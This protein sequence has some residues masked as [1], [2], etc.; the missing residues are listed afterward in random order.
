LDSVSISTRL[1][2][3]IE[4]IDLDNAPEWI[5]LKAIEPRPVGGR[6]L[7]LEI[8]DEPFAFDYNG[9]Q[10]TIQ[11]RQDERPTLFVKRSFVADTF[12]KRLK[13][14][15]EPDFLQLKTRIRQGLRP[16]GNTAPDELI[17]ETVSFR[18]AAPPEVECQLLPVDI[19]SSTLST[20][21]IGILH[22]KWQ[23][24]V[25]Y[26]GS[27]VRLTV[28][29]EFNRPG[30]QL[31]AEIAT[32]IADGASIGIETMNIGSRTTVVADVHDLPAGV[33]PFELEI[34]LMAPIGNV[35]PLIEQF[36][37]S[38]QNQSELSLAC[39]VTATV[40]QGSDTKDAR[41]SRPRMTA[42]LRADMRHRFLL[43][44]DKFEA[45]LAA[46]QPPTDI[47][48][49]PVSVRRVHHQRAIFDHPV[50]EFAVTS[51]PK[52]QNARL[53]CSVR[54]YVKGPRSEILVVPNARL[55]EEALIEEVRV[56]RAR[57]RLPLAEYRELEQYLPTSETGRVTLRAELTFTLKERQASSTY[58]CNLNLLLTLRRAL[59]PICIDIGTSATAVWVADAPV[60]G[61]ATTYRPLPLGEW[62]EEIDEWH[63]E[64]SR[65]TGVDNS[66]LIP[67][68]VGLTWS[69]GLRTQHNPQ[70]LGDVLLALDENTPSR[71]EFLDRTY[72]I[73]LP[74]PSSIKLAS[75]GERV[76]KR[77]KA[78]LAEGTGEIRLGIAI[79]RRNRQTNKI[80]RTHKLDVAKLLEDYIDELVKLYVL[81]HVAANLDGDAAEIDDAMRV[82]QFVITHPCGVGNELRRA[83]QDAVAAIVRRFV[84]DAADFI[85]PLFFTES[86]AAGRFAL[87]HL[88]Q[89]RNRAV[90][91]A[92]DAIVAALDIGAGT[93]DI[94]IFQHNEPNRATPL[95]DFGLP[96]GGDHLDKALAERVSFI[97][98][99]VVANRQASHVLALNDRDRDAYD[100]AIDREIR[101]AKIDLSMKC[102]ERPNF[103]WPADSLYFRMKLMDSGHGGWQSFRLVTVSDPDAR[104]DQQVR[105]PIDGEDVILNMQ[106]S[107]AGTDAV[108]LDIPR[109]L[110]D[111]PKA[112]SVAAVVEVLGRVLPEMA[113][114][115]AQKLMKRGPIP[116]SQRIHVIVTGRTALWPPL[117]AA[118]RQTVERYPSVVFPRPNP[119]DPEIMKSAVVLGAALGQSEAAGSTGHAAQMNP[120]AIVRF[121]ARIQSSAAFAHE[122]HVQTNVIDNITYLT[123]YTYDRTPRPG[124][125]VRTADFS[126]DGVVQLVRVVPGLDKADR[127]DSLNAILARA[128]IFDFNGQTRF[129]PEDFGLGR[130][131][132]TYSCEVASDADGVVTV[133]ITAQ[134]ASIHHVLKISGDDVVR[135]R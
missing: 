70:S 28:M 87:Q 71:L 52:R 49:I 104:Y 32:P 16:A 24:D 107:G 117:F 84:P 112:R 119:F 123:D 86:F 36:G 20:L 78:A 95:V 60:S 83:Y 39:D 94:S 126:V 135:T 108:T 11:I 5:P 41:I 110:L 105:I 120:L 100:A 69:D 92:R 113:V 75:A 51:M 4:E 3:P 40:Q 53:D 88:I 57:L 77:L 9:Y 30:F 14:G 48:P 109:G 127:R 114:E 103:G 89:D 29:L 134:G 61:A 58:V 80:V 96:I 45:D 35:L 19:G 73:S 34:A 31:L 12:E 68:H 65:I 74:F 46:P 2:I 10:A 99:R 63:A 33:D 37:I 64:S 122:G 90:I 72:D 133:M 67:S 121:G 130:S 50:L 13:R 79:D 6:S 42:S 18:R 124:H 21:K 115:S 25:R 38:N 129:C 91:D 93:F 47:G 102:S 17:F 1:P 132:H 55:S 131:A 118:I 26:C 111:G 101:I 8:L 82:P 7:A 27:A 97:L 85:E 54:L 125:P 22:A 76:F 56:N 43:R 66:V 15:E 59:R 81:R 23:R 98:E 62:L 128:P 116:S 106:L 44:C